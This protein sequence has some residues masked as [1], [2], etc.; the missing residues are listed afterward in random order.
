MKE[1]GKIVL[2]LVLLGF[3]F[4]LQYKIHQDYG[5]PFHVDEWQ[6]I[7]KTAQTINHETVL[8]IEPYLKKPQLKVTHEEGFHVFLS[9]LFNT[10]GLNTVTYYKFLAGLSA[11]FTAFTL[12]VFMKKMTSTETALTSILFLATI[13]SNVNILGFWFYTPF[14]ATLPLI[15]L[16]A[17]SIVNAVSRQNTGW[18]INAGALASVQA[19]I[20]PPSFLFTISFSLL[21]LFTRPRRTLKLTRLVLKDKSSIIFFTVLTIALISFTL[22]QSGSTQKLYKTLSERMVFPQSRIPYDVTYSLVKLYGLGASAAAFLGLATVIS[23]R[24][25]RILLFWIFIPYAVIFMYHK[26]DYTLMLPYARALYLGMLG[27]AP[28]SAIGVFSIVRLIKRLLPGGQMMTLTLFIVVLTLML[29]ESFREYESPRQDVGL[30][31]WI[32]DSDY[33]ALYWLG[34][35]YGGGH[36][37]ISPLTKS[38]AVYPV[39]GDYVVAVVSAVVGAGP[40]KTIELFY[41]GT[42]DLKGEIINKHDVEFVLS[43][44]RINCV[45]LEEIYSRGDFIYNVV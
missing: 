5:Y 24:R 40:T 16:Y 3:M 11:A 22:S 26:T 1:K 21:Y 7:A 9:V 27:M 14:T 29:A 44:T 43:D 33:E 8:L 25:L 39:S 15:Y 17:L 12:Y 41:D 18:L 4:T 42:C 36:V 35:N 13:K 2:L 38:V 20:Y 23:D 32:S 10:T 19:L 45:F 31:K 28:L 6:H 37:V 34:E 30:Y